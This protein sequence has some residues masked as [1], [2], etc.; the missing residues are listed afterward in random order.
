MASV[1]AQLPTPPRV[2]WR[3]V[4]CGGVGLVG[5]GRSDRRSRWIGDRPAH[6]VVYVV[7]LGSS[8]PFPFSFPHPVGTRSAHRVLQAFRL[9]NPP[10]LLS[11]RFSSHSRYISRVE[12]ILHLLST[13]C[14]CCLARLTF[15]AAR[16]APVATHLALF[17]SP[18]W[19]QFSSLFGNQSSLPFGIKIVV[20]CLL[21]LLV[22]TLHITR[23]RSV[24]RRQ[25][26]ACPV[27]LLSVF[28]PLWQNLFLLFGFVMAC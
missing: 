18:T 27:C 15:V 7:G 12:H 11:Q 9:F 19:L 1:A 17:Y 21:P 13:Y 10:I 8:T 14:G 20:S 2:A 6:S 4:A 23:K 26:K 5:V 3:K 28:V 24:T 22:T 25:L 16:L